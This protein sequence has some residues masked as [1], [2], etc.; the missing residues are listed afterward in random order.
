MKLNRTVFILLLSNEMRKKDL[1]K[2]GLYN[3]SQKTWGKMNYEE[4]YELF[5]SQIKI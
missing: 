1:Q 3:K 5:I 2:H 4:I